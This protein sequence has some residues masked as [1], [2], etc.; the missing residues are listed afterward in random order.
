MRPSACSPRAGSADKTPVAIVEHPDVRRMLLRMR[1][2][3]GREGAAPLHRRDG[4][5][6]D[7]AA[8][9][10]ADLLE[11]LIKTWG[12]EVGCEMVSLG[13]QVHGGVG[14]IEETGTAQG[15]LLAGVKILAGSL[16]M[17]KLLKAHSSLPMLRA[18]A[19]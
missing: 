17:N 7:A 16:R 6:G 18:I 5:L 2:D 19:L 10:R 9:A 11:P 4:T 12:T 1:A 14:F 8:R 15:D 13:V 3:R